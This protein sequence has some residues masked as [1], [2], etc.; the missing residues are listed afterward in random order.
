MYGT[1]VVSF[2]QKDIDMAST[3]R[4]IDKRR[5]VFAVEQRGPHVHS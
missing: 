4:F 3:H 2:L 1:K 5:E